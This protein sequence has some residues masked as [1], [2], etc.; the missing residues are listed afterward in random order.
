MFINSTQETI[1]LC[2]SYT[3]FTLFF[4]CV[5]SNGIL[6]LYT[7]VMLYAVLVLLITYLIY[8][9]IKYKIHLIKAAQARK[10]RFSVK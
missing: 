1:I 3:V 2:L 5:A 8:L 4:F 6:E 9:S 10:R 7:V